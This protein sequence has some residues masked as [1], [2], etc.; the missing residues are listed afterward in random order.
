MATPKETLWEIEPHT[1]AKHKILENYLK[2]WYPI[3]SKYNDKLNYIDGFSGPGRYS[4]GEPGSPLIVIDVIRNHITE[5]KKEINILCIEERIDRVEH[6]NGEIKKIDLPSNI[7]VNVIMGKFHEVIGFLLEKLD[8]ENKLLAP[9]FVFIDPFG[10]S[11]IP[12]S[13]VRRLLS[14]PKVEVLITFMVDSINRFIDTYGAGDHINEAFGS[15]EASRIVSFSANRIKDLQNLYQKQLEGLVDFVRY[16]EM[17]DKNDKTIYYLFFASKNKLGH[18][19]MK[20]AMWKVDA[21]GDYKFSDATDQH[22]VILFRK[23]NFDLL[24]QE[25]KTKF[26]SQKIDVIEV[27]KYVQEAT[28]FIDKHLTGALKLGEESSI[29]TVETLKKDGSKRKKGT[30][31]DGTIII[32]GK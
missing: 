11:G 26:S 32:F 31:P 24:L 15:D 2:A 25:I 27:R 12:F 17:C 9:T 23:D 10:F 6:L 29:I 4:K 5:Y 14:I 8:S 3:I 16:F 1:L 21:E 20:E 7:H 13:V 19:K 28:P 18:L 30:F 22:Q